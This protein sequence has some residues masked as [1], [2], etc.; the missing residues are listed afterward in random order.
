MT[1]SDRRWLTILGVGLVVVS[2]VLY[3]IHFAIFRDSHHIFIYLMGD[4][5][6]VPLEVLMVALIL[7]RLISLRE[8][9]S[10]AHKLN[11]VIGAFFSELGTP[12]LSEL[13]PAMDAAPQ[14]RERFHLTAL[15][16]K[17]DFYQASR[18]ALTLDSDVDLQRIDLATLNSYLQER[19]QFLL[20]LLENPNLLEHQRFTDLLWAIFHLEEE[21]EARTSLTDLSPTDE[22]HLQLDVRRVYT[23]LAA[24]WVLYV[25]HLKED[26]PYLFS[27]VLRV[28]PFQESPSPVVTA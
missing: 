6:F 24:A 7:D 1:R 5:A 13:L 26:Y 17:V 21:L 14:I 20:R 4:I 2:A 23:Q 28:H 18:F 11:M 8:K 27:L 10:L 3:A 16:K 22:A 9:R 12:L 25:G 15:W 19:R